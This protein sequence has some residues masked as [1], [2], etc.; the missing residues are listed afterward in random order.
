MD[1]I[2]YLGLAALGFGLY[3]YERLV[4]VPKFRFSK[5]IKIELPE[6][7]FLHNP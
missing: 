5:I 2:L 3:W 6:D 4:K 1:Y 7:I